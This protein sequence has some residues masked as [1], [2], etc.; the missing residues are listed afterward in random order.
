MKD[1]LTFLHQHELTS[2]NSNPTCYKN[3]NN[4]SFIDLILTNSPKSFFKT[5]TVFTGLSDF[6]KLVLS[7]F[8]LHFSKAKAKEIS[9]RNFRDFKE[10]SFNRDLQNRLSAQSVEKYAPFEKVFLDILNDHT[11]FKKNVV[12][13]NHA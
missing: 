8:K 10:N 3:P 2:I 1:R 9:W 11:P 5:E 7:V 4:P 6:H 13:A 12:P